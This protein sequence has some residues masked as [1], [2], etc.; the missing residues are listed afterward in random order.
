M[1]FASEASEVS[2][3]VSY[4]VALCI[5]ASPLSACAT[6]FLSGSMNTLFFMIFFMQL[7]E[8]FSEEQN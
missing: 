3:V 4:Y 1:S 6:V 8:M 2:H 5:Q 7:Q